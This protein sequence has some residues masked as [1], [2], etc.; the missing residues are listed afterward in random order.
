MAARTALASMRLS[1]HK[2]E[3]AKTPK[4]KQQK[5]RAG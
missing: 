1:H 5:Q 4:E 2:M 3:Y